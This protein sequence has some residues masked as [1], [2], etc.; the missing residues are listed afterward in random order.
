M[1]QKLNG[2]KNMEEGT[3]IMSREDFKEV[4]QPENAEQVAKEVRE[5]DLFLITSRIY[6]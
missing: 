4:E 1:K 3:L 5:M 2:T 6:C